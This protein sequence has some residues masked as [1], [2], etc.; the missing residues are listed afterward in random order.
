MQHLKIV[1][2]G[3]GAVGKT[4]VLVSYTT[5]SFPTEYTPTIFE[6]FGTNTMVEDKC[7]GLDIYDSAGQED[8]ERLRPLSYPSTDVFLVAFSVISPSSYHNVKS[9]WIV[10]LQ[11]HC[12]DVPI[13]LLGTKID[14]RHDK[15]IWKKLAELKLH[16]VSPE[17]GEKLRDEIKAA[18]Y[19]ECSA[20]TQENIKEAFEIA[21]RAAIAAKSKKAKKKPKKCCFL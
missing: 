4:S 2:V 1:V 12:P 3:D 7:Y 21:I 11:H 17:E 8:Y 18:A 14:L 16:I 20:L 15:Q 5:N 9:K 6:N 10:E 13:V 19:V